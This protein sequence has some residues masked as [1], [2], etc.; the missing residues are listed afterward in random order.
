LKAGR[1]TP[2]REV[3]HIT[4][5]E[6]GGTDELGNLQ[7]ICKACH[8]D[9]TAQEGHAVRKR[10]RNG[11]CFGVPQGMKPSAIPV[12]LI[13]G[14]PGS[15]KTTYAHEIKRPDDLIIDLDDIAEAIG[16]QRWT[17]D[18]SVV[19][20][21]LDERDRMLM[22]LHKP[23]KGRC[24]LIITGSTPTERMAWMQRLGMRAR[25]VVMQ[26]SAAE[27]LR[28]IKAEPARVHAVNR[29]AEVIRAWR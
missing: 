29:Q 16:G 23:R 7:S 8:A 19:R 18:L 25:L 24:I 4:P 26:T 10:Q 6:Q 17:G 12:L 15:G 28:R 1:Y 9:K 13:A 5:K 27:C 3:D 20:R 22:A 2:A 21:A 11:D 14:P